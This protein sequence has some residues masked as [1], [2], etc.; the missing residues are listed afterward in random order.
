[1]YHHPGGIQRF[2]FKSDNVMSQLTKKVQFLA[3]LTFDF[4]LARYKWLE[5]RVKYRNTPYLTRNSISQ[6][7]RNI[8]VP[9]CHKDSFGLLKVYGQSPA[10]GFDWLCFLMPRR[11]IYCH[12]HFSNNALRQFALSKIGFV[13]SNRS[14]WRAPGF[15]IF[16]YPF[17]FLSLCNLTVFRLRRKVA[18]L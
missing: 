7:S 13:F 5:R 2:F 6:T 18:P 16:H 11:Q 1:M 4:A 8:F 17:S 3:D 15:T 10:I 14:R 9:L 12:N